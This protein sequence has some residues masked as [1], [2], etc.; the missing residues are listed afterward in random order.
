MGKRLG[1]VIGLGEDD[2]H[3]GEDGRG[4][5]A[6]PAKGTL[7]S[8]ADQRAASEGQMRHPADRDGMMKTSAAQHQGNLSRGAAV[9][10]GQVPEWLRREMEQDTKL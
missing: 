1:P 6:E 2:I 7:E 10:Q 4:F 8:F 9:Q 3:I 5:Q